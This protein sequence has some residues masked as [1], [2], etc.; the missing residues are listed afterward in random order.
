MGERVTDKGTRK[1]VPC[2]EAR[3]EVWCLEGR[4]SGTPPLVDEFVPK[5]TT[6][7]DLWST[8]FNLWLTSFVPKGTTS[9]AFGELH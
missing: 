3:T 2:A 1:G 9:F 4:S 7:F 8:S 6:S 5:D